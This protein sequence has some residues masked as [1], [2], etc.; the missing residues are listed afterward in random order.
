MDGMRTIADH[1]YN[2]TITFSSESSFLNPDLP[3]I[4]FMLDEHQSA[5]NDLKERAVSGGLAFLIG[6]MKNDHRLP[7]FVAEVHKPVKVWTIDIP[8]VVNKGIQRIEGQIPP[9]KPGA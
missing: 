3:Q 6:M 4:A 2:A 7:G 8:L 5:I 9:A 1:L